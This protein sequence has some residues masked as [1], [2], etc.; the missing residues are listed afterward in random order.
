MPSAQDC[1]ER[2]REQA[3]RTLLPQVQDL[4]QE[5]KGVSSSLLA[6]LEKIERKLESLRKTEL[7]TTELVLN[8]ILENLVQQKDLE[9]NA[10]VLFMRGLHQKETQEEILS[11]LLDG[12]LQFYPRVALFAVRGGRIIGWSS[13][14]FVETLARNISACSFSC[15]ENPQFEAALEGEDQ[16][17]A[18]EFAEDSP[19][20]FLR[21]DGTTPWNL[22]PLK[23]MQRPVALLLTGG[24][25]NRSDAA[26]IMVGLAA[27][28][29]ENVALKILHDLSVEQPR[30]VPQRFVE[31]SPTVA[32]PARHEPMPA[33]GAEEPISPQA[34][35]EEIRPETE[36]SINLEP[37]NPQPAHVEF[38]PEPA[39]EPEAVSMKDVEQSLAAEAEAAAE[40]APAPV[41]LPEAM[42]TQQHESKAVPEEEKLHADAKRFARLLVTEIKLYNEHHVKEGRVNCDLYLRL[43]RDIDRSREMYEK[44]ISPV[45]S[46]KI[47][48]FHD[49][50]IRILGDND[51]STL[52]SDYPGPRVES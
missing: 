26:A 11:F 17:V 1:A 43:K 50:I 51:P 41:P 12:I 16:T 34:P 19:L 45:V 31:E 13:G 46:R 38:Q 39:P 30:S 28:R 37:V 18:P 15:S 49:E 6:G 4:E 21:E 9:A 14:G 2:L 42:I 33:I 44:R 29:L 40:E 25:S 10:L 20:Q 32:P 48:Y 3:Y 35:V 22:L 47:D 27:F 7:P 24:T 36:Y 5:L 52:G 23:A 8:E